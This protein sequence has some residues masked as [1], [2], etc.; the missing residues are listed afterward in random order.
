MEVTY[1]FCAK[2]FC[3]KNARVKI[4][5]FPNKNP[6]NQVDWSYSTNFRRKQNFEGSLEN[7][8]TYE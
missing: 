2:N 6:I 7:F 4:S 8:S 1:K 5:A 3:K